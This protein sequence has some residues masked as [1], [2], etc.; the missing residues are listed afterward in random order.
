MRPHIYVFD[1]SNKVDFCIEC[2]IQTNKLE[3]A[4]PNVHIVHLVSGT[5]SAC[6]SKR[7]VCVYVCQKVNANTRFSY[8]AY[9]LSSGV[10]L[11][12]YIT[13]MTADRQ[14][15]IY[16]IVIECLSHSSG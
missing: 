8:F 9:L 6:T 10:F 16:A 13:S 5:E 11:K 3:I 14:L 12:L 4:V 2:L 15:S 1:S 7:G